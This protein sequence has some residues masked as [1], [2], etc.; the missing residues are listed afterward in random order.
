ME[1]GKLY[2]STV[3]RADG[4]L[5]TIGPDGEF[6][7]VEPGVDQEPVIKKLEPVADPNLPTDE[8]AQP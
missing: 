1:E 4:V 3:R 2:Q 5:C 6:V 8:E 7:P